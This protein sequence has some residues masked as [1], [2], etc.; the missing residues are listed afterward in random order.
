MLKDYN[1]K[2]LIKLELSGIISIY[3]LDSVSTYFTTKVRL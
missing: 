2:S 3:V 1:L